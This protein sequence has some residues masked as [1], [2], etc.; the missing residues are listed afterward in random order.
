MTDEIRELYTTEIREK[1]AAASGV[2]HKKGRR[3]LVGAM[4]TPA[5]LSGKEYKSPGTLEEFHVDDLVSRLESSPILKTL[6]LDRMD[7]QY[8]QYRQAT[9]QTLDLLTDILTE[10]LQRFEKEAE[11]LR[12]RIARLENQSTDSLAP[13]KPPYPVTLNWNPNKRIRWGSTPEEIRA[14]VFRQLQRLQANGNPICVETIKSEVPGMLRW[15]YGEKA[16]FNGLKGLQQE[17]RRQM[18]RYAPTDKFEQVEMQ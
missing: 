17:Y 16:V 11:S 1:K 3:G 4:I 7:D 5:D 13:N 10:S 2:H 8:R 9:E 14:A 12:Y 6:I 15:L 18:E